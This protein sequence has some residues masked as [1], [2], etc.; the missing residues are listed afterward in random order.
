MARDHRPGVVHRMRDHPV[1]AAERAAIEGGKPH[2]LA[3]QVRQVGDQADGVAV[4]GDPR[5]SGGARGPG[6][7][8]VNAFGR[9]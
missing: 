9:H 5:A 6:M 2:A 3:R 7:D 1:A 4:G 8:D